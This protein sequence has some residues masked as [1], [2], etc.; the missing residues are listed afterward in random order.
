M[1]KPGSDSTTVNVAKLKN[2]LS[3]YLRLTKAGKE[4]V[5]LEHKT[6]IAKLVPIDS[7]DSITCIPAPTSPRILEEFER[8]LHRR[9]SWQ[10]LDYL[11]RDRKGR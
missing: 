10:S 1:K 3:K 5:V 2:D 7:A 9:R 8:L 6:P 11:L 4:V